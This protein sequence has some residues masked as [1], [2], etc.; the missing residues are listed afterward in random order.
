MKKNV[1]DATKAYL[2][3]K[4]FDRLSRSYKASGAG[5]DAGKFTYIYME[6]LPACIT[7][8]T[9]LPLYQI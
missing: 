1:N 6:A 8:H 5:V 4:V 2:E 9:I 7:V 3:E